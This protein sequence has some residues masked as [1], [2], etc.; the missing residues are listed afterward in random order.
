MG[1]GGGRM[2]LGRRRGGGEN[3]CRRGNMESRRM[4]GKNGG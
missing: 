3:R 2:R 4:T 1:E